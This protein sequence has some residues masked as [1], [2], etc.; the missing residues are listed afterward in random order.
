[1]IFVL[2]SPSTGVII[3]FILNPAITNRVIYET[4]ERIKE[5]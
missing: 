3:G 1:M 5:V 4:Q 2:I